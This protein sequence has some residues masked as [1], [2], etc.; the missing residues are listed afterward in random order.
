MTTIMERIDTPYKSYEGHGSK[1]ELMEAFAEG[2]SKI[3]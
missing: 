2:A 3:V 1:L